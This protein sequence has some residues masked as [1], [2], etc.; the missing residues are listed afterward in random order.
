[1]DNNTYFDNDYNTDN[2]D[3][4]NNLNYENYDDIYYEN[5]N[6]RYYEN[7]NNDE[8]IDD[9][10]I[11]YSDGNFMDD[12][13]L[14]DTLLNDKNI[15]KYVLSSNSNN[16]MIT[17]IWGPPLWKSLH[18]IT[19]GFPINPSYQDKIKYK[20]F[21]ESL[22]DVLPCKYCR[23][24]YKKFIDEPDTQL[25]FDV[26]NNRYTL[27]K[28]LYDIH[29][30]VNNKL[31]MNYGVKFKDIVDRYETYRAKCSNN[32]CSKPTNYNCYYVSKYKDCPI[33]SL[34]I[35]NKFY[36]LANSKI[37]NKSHFYII[38][39]CNKNNIDIDFFIKN[40]NHDLWNKRNN[41]CSRIIDFMRENNI[42]SID[43]D[44]LPTSF[45]L[46]LIIRLSS[47]LSFDQLSNIINNHF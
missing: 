2:F 11:D 4:N 42:P 26:L 29:N 3:K 1:M 38:D 9:N 6:N 34:A 44:G 31:G 46:H 32:S 39:F 30:K 17:K 36:N 27:S 28:W 22:G 15:N 7:N 13:N 14:T 5:S 21:F 23:E 47:N 35:A 25:T 33:I 16:G 19:F 10:F 8:D 45:E 18:T 20:N 12:D 40:K 41:D 43:Y 24:S 37:K